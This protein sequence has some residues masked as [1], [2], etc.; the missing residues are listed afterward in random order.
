MDNVSKDFQ[1]SPH[2]LPTLKDDQSSMA[3]FVDDL[4]ELQLN[5]PDMLVDDYEQYNNDRQEVVNISPDDPTEEPEP[6]IR[7]DDCRF[8]E[9]PVLS[10]FWSQR[11][12]SCPGIGAHLCCD[13]QAR[14]K[15]LY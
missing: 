6:E 15:M 12:L 10:T 7:A 11:L 9:R 14:P 8:R 4:S 5:G 1:L 3:D 2:K 13:R